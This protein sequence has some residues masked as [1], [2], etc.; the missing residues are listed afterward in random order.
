MRRSFIIRNTPQEWNT[1][2]LTEA[3]FYRHCDENGIVLHEDLQIKEKGAYI[4]FDDRANIFIDERL[5]GFERLLVAF[6][7]LAHFW[8]HPAKVKHYRGENSVAEAEAEVVSI[9]AVIPRAIIEHVSPERICALYG[10]PI[11][12]VEKRLAILEQWRL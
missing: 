2:F 1:R 4:V 10:Y 8:L 5:R 3:D 12:L 11:S 9:C 7:E 6:H